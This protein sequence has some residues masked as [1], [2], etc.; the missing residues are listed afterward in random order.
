MCINFV[1]LI[2][3]NY[4]IVYSNFSLD[5]WFHRFKIHII[6]KNLTSSF[7]VCITSLAYLHQLVPQTKPC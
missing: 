4:L 6:Y 7:Q 1:V 3:L 5:L 2:F